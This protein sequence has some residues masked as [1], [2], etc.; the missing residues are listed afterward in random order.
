[1]ANPPLELDSR[2][3]EEGAR[4]GSQETERRDVPWKS[5]AGRG[6]PCRRE[7]EQS[8]SRAPSTTGREAESVSGCLEKKPRQG[9]F[10]KIYRPRVGSVEGLLC[11]IDV[12][13]LDVK[14]VV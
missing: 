12:A 7:L 3:N 1:M 14:G 9:V 13:P 4:A 6:A 8:G 11:K 5:R 10:G 2:K